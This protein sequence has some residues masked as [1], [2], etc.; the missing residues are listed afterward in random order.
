M[1][2]PVSLL[3]GAALVALLGASAF[4]YSRYSQTSSQLAESK[5]NEETARTRYAQ[6]IDAIAEIQD[7][8]NAISVGDANVRLVTDKF[9]SEKDLTTPNGRDALDRIATLRQ[10]IQRNKDRIH[11]LESSLQAS[12]VQV[13]GLK[14]MVA[15]LNQ[16][17]KEKE[18]QVAEL[19]GRVD[20]LSTQV[21][22]LETTVADNQQQI[23]QKDE[24]IEEKRREI[25]T[26]YYAVGKKQDLQQRG[27]IIAKGGLFGIGKTITPVGTVAATQLTPIDTDHDTVIP[28]EA[29]RAEVVTAQPA[30]S[31]ELRP[32]A[33]ETGKMELHILDP[34]EFRKVRQLV[35]VTA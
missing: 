17:V 9:Q 13:K 1:R 30:S 33:G 8:L 27:L 18:A 24:S 25:A 4:L 7:S 23:A 29:V 32:V 11:Q 15:N 3:L 31:Y 34:N 12:G 2:R 35:I 26:V 21:S 16:S 20:A 14:R 6:T 19:S 5:A 28:I 22:S 10:S